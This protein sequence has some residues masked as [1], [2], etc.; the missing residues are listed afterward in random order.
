[1]KRI[2][3]TLLLAAITLFACQTVS[4]YDF[5]VDGIYYNINSYMTANVTCG[6]HSYAGNIVIPATVTYNTKTLYV[7][8]VDYYAF[9][10]DSD[11]LSVQLPASINRIRHEAFIGCTKLTSIV[12][13]DEITEIGEK[14]FSGC[15][16]LSSVVLPKRLKVLPNSIFEGCTNLS[17]IVLPDSIT[18]IEKRAFSG[19]SK[20]KDITFSPNITTIEN[21]VFYKCKNL[22]HVVLPPLITTIKYRTFYWCTNLSSIT[23]PENVTEIKE[24]AFYACWRMK[25]IVLSKQLKTI[26]KEA[27]GHCGIST[28]TIPN[29]VTYVSDAFT[30]CRELTRLIIE[31]GTERLYFGTKLKLSYLYLGR[32]FTKEKDYYLSGDYTNLD[33]GM[34]DTLV[35]GSTF[36][37]R[38]FPRGRNL[39]VVVSKIAKP[40]GMNFD[41][42]V[43]ANAILYVPVG[44]KAL[45]ESTDG[46]KQ[47]FNIQEGDPTTGIVS[48]KDDVNKVEVSRYDI[49]GQRLDSPRKGINI[50]RYSDGTTAKIVVQ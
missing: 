41:S 36:S 43:Y 44:T 18:S 12:L 39:K 5:E 37:D 6:D 10:G 25:S 3:T 24:E 14:A 30:G 7:T 2:Y 19:C 33:A 23:I 49:N 40:Y 16:N 38:S 45:Y 21:E 29:H 11:L 31:D 15:T 50:V 13:P 42:K 4:A 9:R 35:F 17:S 26:E 22:D 20:L 46:W 48:T 27:F 47:F 32:N 8:G 28:L 1:M 34:L